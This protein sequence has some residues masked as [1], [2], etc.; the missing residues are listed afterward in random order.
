MKPL[1]EVLTSELFH[2]WL[3]QVPNWLVVA[4]GVGL[5]FQ[6][7]L[8]SVRDRI[9]LGIGLLFAALSSVMPLLVRWA[10]SDPGL[11]GP[12]AASEETIFS[13]VATLPQTLAF[14]LLIWLVIRQKAV[15]C[16]PVFNGVLQQ[17]DSLHKSA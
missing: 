9:V 6:R 10:S 3:G 2:Y 12:D 8:F 15:G 7:H 4:V 13:F 16:G 14:A 11:G 1:N 17:A 5:L